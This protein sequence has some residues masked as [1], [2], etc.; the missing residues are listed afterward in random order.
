MFG[1]G[2]NSSIFGSGG[3]SSMFDSGSSGG[4]SIFDKADSNS[5]SSIFGGSNEKK[6]VKSSMF[7][8]PSTPQGSMF[9][10]PSTPQGSMF[11]SPSTPQGSMF[12]SP[13]TPQGGMFDSPSTPQG[14]MF[15]SPQNQSLDLGG[16]ID[17]DN[18]M[19]KVN[20][21]DLSI[22]DHDKYKASFLID[23]TNTASLNVRGNNY[24]QMNLLDRM[25]GIQS[26]RLNMELDNVSMAEQYSDASLDKRAMGGLYNT[27]LTDIYSD[28]V[29]YAA[30]HGLTYDGYVD[31]KDNEYN[32]DTY[33]SASDNKEEFT[34]FGSDYTKET[35]ALGKSIELGIDST[36]DSYEN[37]Y[38]NPIES[39]NK[40]ERNTRKESGLE[41]QKDPEVNNFNNIGTIPKSALDIVG[42]TIGTKELAPG[43]IESEKE[44]TPGE[45]FKLQ[46]VESDRL[47]KEGRIQKK[48]DE[49]LEK[50]QL[51]T[52]KKEASALD[53]INKVSQAM[54]EE[55]TTSMY[56]KDETAS[57]SE[58]TK[59]VFGGISG[60][61]I[62]SGSS[63][64]ETKKQK[65]I[66]DEDEE[67]EDNIFAKKDL[68][69]TK[70]INKDLYASPLN[71]SEKIMSLGEEKKEELY[72]SNPM[73]SFGESELT[74]GEKFKLRREE[75]DLLEK[76]GRE[77]KK[78][79]GRLEKEQLKI[80]R[81]EASAL[82]HINK[83]S[84]AMKVE[85]VSM[86]GTIPGEKESTTVSSSGSV[87]GGLG[88][89]DLG[90]GST[91]AETKKHKSIYD[92]DEEE[93]EEDNIFAKKDHTVAKNINKSMFRG[94]KKKEEE[95]D[96]LNN[97]FAIGGA[98]TSSKGL[99]SS[100]PMDKLGDKDLLPGEKLKLEKEQ[101][102][103]MEKEGREQK[104]IDGKLEKEQMKL[105][106]REASA[107]DHINKISK[108]MKVE[109][110]SMFGAIPGEKESTTVSS[111]GS[112]LGGLGGIDLGGG[113][114]GSETKKHKSIYDKDEEE[115]ED[116]I[117]AK[118]DH[119][120]AKNINK[121]MFR[122]DKKKED[123]EDELLSNP[124]AIGGAATSSKGLYSSNPMDKL[125]DKDLLPGEKLKLEKEQKD[126]MEKEGREQK[127]MDGKLE[128]EQMKLERREA[129]S[130]E[131]IEKIS[132][133][134]KTEETSMFATKEEVKDSNSEKSAILGGLGGIDL[135]G[136]S[137]G[138]E[139]KKYKSIYDK[140]EEEEED[141]IFAKKD[142]TVAKN[143]NKA[144]FRGDKKKEEEE[145]ELLTNP[146]AIGGAA[147]SSKGLYSSNPMD[148][149][150]DKDLLPGDKL[151]LEKEQKDLMEKEA[152]EQKKMDG[153]L[154][155]EQMKLERREAE[156]LEHIEKISQSYK[157]EE[158]SIFA[159]KD[160]DKTKSKNSDTSAIL[161]TLSGI[162]L[163]S[164]STGSET[165]K[166]K[167][168]YDEDEEEEDNIF[169]RKDHTFV[170]NINK[171]MYKG[172]KKDEDEDEEDN[173]FAK[174]EDNSVIKTSYGINGSNDM[175]P[176][177]RLRGIKD[178]ERKIESE[179]RD[180]RKKE[181]KIEKAKERRADLDGEKEAFLAGLTKLGSKKEENKF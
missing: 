172:D 175:S 65:S 98:V 67:E 5:N 150:G 133:S 2:N 161:G 7:D 170:K 97:P 127:K 29:K 73:D 11:D 79:D 159:T 129:E 137:T 35:A 110:V 25:R 124:F 76:E 40:K 154:E 37:N 117:F 148:K 167:S 87:L 168:I 32:V 58:E 104:K 116:N 21:Q 90:G 131:H 142:H 169:A 23:E 48:L 56:I 146:F 111:S 59:T 42:S 178:K 53:H 147:T 88:G 141:N 145:D 123:E 143:I 106:R 109:E 155:K 44:L 103:L 18:K 156:S 16:A 1:S 136:G 33:A 20:N 45:K 54:K 126:L 86:F 3:G 24:G 85:E 49:K 118:K 62:A 128:K 140:D 30:H 84:K 93:D 99:Y 13:S 165:K 144:M 77:Q 105:E 69:Q 162:D 31:I 89:I 151:K 81:Q 39:F 157:T 179:E 55:S 158:T 34:M 138:S 71:K 91:G 166:Y 41:Y 102:D 8:S 36:K 135:G 95:E 22:G 139:T 82:D 173:I 94:D 52:E 134:Y 121:A 9:D 47:E 177:E 180:H 96:E 115:E 60:L 122:G 75:S 174:K 101:K 27:T 72:S 119:T 28:S 125:G 171:A 153:R 113:S 83:I 164:G 19:T 130:L 50:E 43:E 78:I 160:T 132:Q 17:T 14:G 114:T 149:L 120:V 80:E 63:G 4:S 12:D 57:S 70:K 26:N 51:K 46:R 100:N 112:V 92:K 163:G 181:R 107:L 176:E 66:Y 64:T 10:S 74:P 61:D 15:D 6:E 152:R 68:S 108:S 38:E